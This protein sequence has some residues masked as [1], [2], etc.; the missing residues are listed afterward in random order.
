MLDHSAC[1]GHE[2]NGML[3]PSMHC[4]FYLIKL[5]AELD[6]PADVLGSKAL[7]R[8]AYGSATPL[9][10]THGAE[11][12]DADRERDV[13]PVHELHRVGGGNVARLLRDVVRRQRFAGAGQE[14]WSWLAPF[15]D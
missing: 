4:L 15:P 1:A 10:E 13:T 11:K 2:G 8:F 6:V 5:A 7:V 3:Q 14:A 9:P 12:P